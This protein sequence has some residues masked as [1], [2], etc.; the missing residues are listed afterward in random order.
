L[1]AQRHPIEL[2]IEHKNLVPECDQARDRLPGRG[3]PENGGQRKGNGQRPCSNCVPDWCPQ[4]VENPL[5]L[6]RIEILGAQI[7][8]CHANS[9]HRSAEAVSAAAKGEMHHLDAHKL[10]TR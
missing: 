3:W 4:A 10:E 6:P 9:N 5:A 7:L 2:A 8:R 1:Q